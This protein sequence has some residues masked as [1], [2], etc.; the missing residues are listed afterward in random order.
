MNQEDISE[1]CDEYISQSTEHMFSP[2]HFLTWLLKSHHI[3]PNSKVSAAYEIYTNPDN[4]SYMDY[5]EHYADGLTNGAQRALD[6]IF[7]ED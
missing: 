2:E 1:L 6:Y 5:V 3:I 7:D 4:I